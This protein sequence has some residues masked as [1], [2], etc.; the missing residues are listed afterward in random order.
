MHEVAFRGGTPVDG[1]G[2]G[3]FRIGGYLHKGGLLILPGRVAQWAPAWP[4]T[5]GD[6]ADAIAA[7]GDIDVLLVGMGP[8]IAPLPAPVRAA[9]EA[10]GPGVDAMATPA[11]CGAYN[12]LLAEERR[13]AAALLPV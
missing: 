3:V 8:D 12:V 10:A 13:V 7:A 4:L 5:V 2:P 6:F 1:Y 9:I 11:A